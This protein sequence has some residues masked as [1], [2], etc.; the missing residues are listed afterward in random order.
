MEA[1][2]LSN[3]SSKYHEFA[4]I[5]SK[6]KAEVLTPHCSYDLKINL[7][8]GAQPPVGSIY[9]LSASEQE[10]LK[11]FIEENLNTGFIQPTS[12]SHSA[13]V[14]FVK[15]K[16][17]SLHLCI[18]FCGLN[19]ISKKDHYPLLL[20]SDLLD[21]PHKARV[22]SK[23]D[24]YYV[25][26]LV[27]ITNGDEWKTA[28]RTHYRSFEWYV[29]PFSLTNAPMAFQQFMNDIFSDILDVCVMIYLDDVLIYLN[30]MSKHHRHVK[31][32]LKCLRKAGFYAKVEKC[33]FHSKSVEYLG[34]ILSPSGLTMSDNKVKIIQDWP[35]PKK[36]KDIQS[37]LGFA[38]FYC[39]FIFN[40]SDIVILL[41]RLTQKDIPWKFNSSCH[42]AFNS[43]KK[44]FT[45][46]PIVT[47]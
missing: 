37:F 32:V 28:F 5:F 43:L 7:E 15:K 41:T 14:L 25:Y 21:S 20:I 1:P 34:Y 10:A 36:V 16:D 27:C 42:D 19:H 31:E 9:S 17:G 6:T 13:P 12:S 22:Y 8:E 18:N 3:V 30:N 40:Y 46:A 23:I 39:R 47:H 26:H 29:M 24:L 35:E 33:K 45:S 4:D 11:K 2:D 44:A 38:N